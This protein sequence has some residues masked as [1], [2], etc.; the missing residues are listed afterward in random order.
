M[1]ED[2]ILNPSY[3]Q[4]LLNAQWWTQYNSTYTEL[5]G[6]HCTGGHFDTYLSKL[7]NLIYI[8]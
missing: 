7:F 4:S 3:T 2:S 5:L 1:V 6:N 8:N